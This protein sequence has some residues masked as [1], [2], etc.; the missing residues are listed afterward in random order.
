MNKAVIN[1]NFFTSEL[2]DSGKKEGSGGK[3][4]SPQQMIDVLM[5][6]QSDDDFSEESISPTESSPHDSRNQLE[7]VPVSLFTADA[8]P[9]AE[10]TDP[11]D[12]KVETKEAEKLPEEEEK[13][14]DCDSEEPRS[15]LDDNQT[16]SLDKD[17]NET[18]EEA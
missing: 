17:K 12:T 3:K 10:V 5:T 13:K 4:T 2:Q 7:D 6:P 14:T 8:E 9:E 16:S 1:A 11:L 18:E 15:T